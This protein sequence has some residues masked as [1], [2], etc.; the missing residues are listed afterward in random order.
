MAQTDR[1]TT[2]PELDHLLR[3][4]E[5]RPVMLFKHSTTCSVSSMAL[6]TWREFVGRQ[7]SGRARYA[8]LEV[9]NSRELSNEVA[10]VTGVRHESPQALVLRHRRAVWSASHWNISG[11]SL[12]RGL[13]RAKDA[14]GG[15]GVHR[16][17]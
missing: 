9:Q 3:E 11:E 1:I 7:D 2:R 13:A 15:N 4:S 17:G 14:A 10:R 16:G 6:D 8:L 12:E 5:E